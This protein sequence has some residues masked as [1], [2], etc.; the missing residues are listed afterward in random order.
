MKRNVELILKG[1]GKLE[2]ESKILDNFGLEVTYN[3]NDVEDVGSRKT[4]YSKSF[5][6]VGTPK[7]NI[8][9]QHIYDINFESETFNMNAKQPCYLVVNKNIVM[10]GYLKLRSISKTYIAG[11]YQIIYNVNIFDEIKDIFVE[12]SN[13]NLR[14]LD[15]ST[16]FTFMET[17]YAK[18]D[19]IFNLDSIKSSQ[20]RLLSHTNV[21]DYPIVNW[22]Y[23]GINEGEL[24]PR[25]QGFTVSQFYPSVY[26][27][28]II[29]KIFYDIGY[30]YESDFFN[31]VVYDNIFSS[32]ATI[33]NDSVML[34]S[35]S[36]YF[37]QIGPKAGQSFEFIYGPEFPIDP[38]TGLPIQEYGPVQPDND[39]PTARTKIISTTN[40]TTST[41][42][43]TDGGILIVGDG[44]YNFSGTITH[45]ALEVSSAE[46]DRN[47][48]I[49]IRNQDDDVLAE[50]VFDTLILDT[51][52]ELTFETLSL[53]AGDV[54]YMYYNAGYR[55]FPFN[56]LGNPARWYDYQMDVIVLNNENIIDKYDTEL[57]LSDFLPNI[58]QADFLKSLIKQFNLYL[59]PV[60]NIEKHVLIEPRRIFYNKG[61]IVDWTNKVV[62]DKVLIEPL[63]KKLSK[64]YNFKMDI[65][66]SIKTDSYYDKWKINYGS[67][68]IILPYDDITSSTSVDSQFSGYDYQYFQTNN[69][70]DYIF[71]PNF[72]K[73]IK[74]SITTQKRE[75]PPTIGF[76][77][78]HSTSGLNL[79]FVE[80]NGQII[81][82][83]NT[84]CHVEKFGST[85][86]PYD[87]NFETKQGMPVG[88][89]NSYETF[90][91]SH[92]NNIF[93]I[94]NRI[95][96]YYVDLDI[97]D[98]KN[99]DFKNVVL[100]KGELYY[101]ESLVVDL[102]TYR[103]S[104][105][106]LVKAYDYLK[107]TIPETYPVL[108]GLVD[109]VGIIA[110][111]AGRPV[112]TE[113]MLDLGYSI[114]INSETSF[115]LEPNSTLEN[116]FW[117]ATPNQSV[118]NKKHS[119]A[120]NEYNRGSIGGEVNLGGNLF[121]DP[122][123]IDFHG[124]SYNV[125][126]ANYQTF[127]DIIKVDFEDATN[128]N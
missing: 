102:N 13:R 77:K 45:R 95:I 89:I 72:T 25:P 33:Y 101:I 35:T 103:P 118:L 41:S 121:P 80:D 98:I 115:N 15:F 122:D 56:Y 108:W 116:Y 81:N 73:D 29:D 93:N 48:R 57:T 61:K 87:L 27:K 107:Y 10:D 85:K 32:L 105:L 128:I 26:V 40:Y 7:N 51:P 24:W 75:I 88:T 66:K 31:G 17:S 69:N 50:Y 64:T 71:V 18:G 2:L 111:G 79:G 23:N 109:T 16:G 62:D 8:L 52:V 1:K 30:T 112:A 124:V 125:Y 92:M 100:I 12:L 68:D 44:N 28:A 78:S 20:A 106:E 58:S 38:S 126:I 65:I 11:K 39:D 117:F 54:I 63:N 47:D 86:T 127:I 84:I 104:K 34:S 59:Y 53:N 123:I 36:K 14:D 60:Q 42:T 114:N 113:A 55:F 22:N 82:N 91:E 96:T 5:N 67:K 37:S 110:S 90:W 76:I 9:F 3:I 119:W 46:T 94:N 19:H 21:F 49:Q 70:T 120:V 83:W 74:D 4:N 97:I 6:I 99:L 43:R